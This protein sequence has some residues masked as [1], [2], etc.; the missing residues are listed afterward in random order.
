MA[1]AAEPAG[2]RLPP[3]DFAALIA[4]LR[5]SGVELR[6]EPDVLRARLERFR[7][8]Y[9]PYA[10]VLAARLD[11]ALPPWLAPESPTD[12]WRTTAWH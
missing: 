7:G 12:N 2:D 1:P 3:A 11:L 6:D 8:L 9:E 10:Q 4:E 5:A